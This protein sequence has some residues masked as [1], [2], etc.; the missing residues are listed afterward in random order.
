MKTANER[1]N[2]ADWKRVALESVHEKIP[3]WKTVGAFHASLKFIE[4]YSSEPD[5][6]AEAKRGL[7]LG[8]KLF[9]DFGQDRML[10][11]LLAA[12]KDLT[13]PKT[14]EEVLKEQWADLDAAYEK[15]QLEDLADGTAEL[16]KQIDK[17]T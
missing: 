8:E 15:R 14:I 11:T 1:K 16:L 9:R 13:K 7:D 4:A 2:L 12:R 10:Q 3:L 5:M 17:N 6:V